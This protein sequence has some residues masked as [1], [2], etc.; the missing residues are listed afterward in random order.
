MMKCCLLRAMVQIFLEK[1][2]CLQEEINGEKHFVFPSQYRRERCFPTVPKTF[3]SYSFSGELQSIYTTLVVRLWYSN[4]FDNKELWK[5]AAEFTAIDGGTAGFIM[6]RHGD[7]KATLAVFFESVQ[8]EDKAVFL[9][10]I[11][12]HLKKTASDLSRDRQY[13][14]P[15]CLKPVSDLDAV[16]YRLEIGREEIPCVFCDYL[17]PLVDHI[18][19]QLESDP[20]AR[21][22]L[23]M[24]ETAGIE[25]SSQ[26]LEQ[27]LIGHMMTICGNANQVFRPT[28][29]A[30]Y[31]INGEVEF[32]DDNGEVT[33]KKIYLQLKNGSSYLR[34]RKRD[35]AEVFD[36]K[37]RHIEYWL[38]QPCDVYL[39][40]RDGQQKIRWMNVTEY[41]DRR[42]D[43]QSRQIVFDGEILD[44]ESMWQAR[45][46][47]LGYTQVHNPHI[48]N[49]NRMSRAKRSESHRV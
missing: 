30:D 31:G 16:R 14:C 13:V 9:K 32:R 47:Y 36:A 11:H 39:V 18:E 23:E 19:Q 41:L 48:A 22:V 49:R 12:Q 43:K 37:Q 21:K 34:D 38:S 7:G 4:E 24:D 40:I 27:I 26:A 29:M 20:V 46:R 6:H 3:V 2:L 8:D 10:F 15:D 45:D 35:Q 33:G 1:S 44:T 17:I 28:V 42:T 25:L 5:D